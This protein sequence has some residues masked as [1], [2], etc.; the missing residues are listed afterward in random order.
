MTYH[1][2]HIRIVSE[3]PPP[4]LKLDRA[5]WLNDE[6]VESANVGTGVKKVWAQIFGSWGS[7]EPG[8]SAKKAKVVKR[9]SDV[10]KELIKKEPVKSGEKV[11]KRIMMPMMPSRASDIK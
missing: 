9:K 8:A 1:V 3:D 5:V 7:F 2:Q 4:E 11:V 6:A 10:K